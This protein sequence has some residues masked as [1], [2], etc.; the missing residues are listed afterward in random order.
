MLLFNILE[1]TKLPV[2][3]P[4]MKLAPTIKP[5][6]KFTVSFIMKSTLDCFE[7]FCNPI[8]NTINKLE[9]KNI[10]KAIFL[11]STFF[12]FY[13]NINTNYK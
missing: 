8:I 5:I 9:L 2:S 1:D 4:Q 6:G 13:G 7:L 3:D 12:M 11:K 10:K